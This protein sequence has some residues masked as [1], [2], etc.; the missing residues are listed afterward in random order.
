MRPFCRSYT[1][2]K[3]SV[4]NKNK[5]FKIKMEKKMKINLQETREK[6][7]TDFKAFTRGDPRCSF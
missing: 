1:M 6:I 7:N 4:S 5:I 3:F 2:D